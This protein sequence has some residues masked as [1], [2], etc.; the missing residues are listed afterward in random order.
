MVISAQ[1]KEKKGGEISLREDSYL[2][3]IIQAL[4]IKKEELFSQNDNYCISLKSD[5]IFAKEKRIEYVDY[6]FR[7]LAFTSKELKSATVTNETI[8][9]SN[10]ALLG[11]ATHKIIELYWDSFQKNSETILDKMMILEQLHR[12]IITEHMNI[13]YKSE[14]YKQLQAGV[15]HH[16]ELEFNVDDSVGFIDFIYHDE[17]RN[18]WIIVDFKTGKETRQKNE[19]YQKQLDFYQNVMEGLDYKIVETRLLWL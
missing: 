15:Q 18:G 12:N 13:F 16:F 11:T 2:N 3:M 8:N 9:Q 1:L 10:A 7:E 14:V 6:P 19:E 4:D 5:D 17:Q